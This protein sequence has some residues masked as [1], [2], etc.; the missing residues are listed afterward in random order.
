MTRV[1]SAAHTPQLLD[2]LGVGPDNAAALLITAGDN[3]SRLASDASFV[4]LCG[5][6]DGVSLL[7]VR[8]VRPG[9]IDYAELG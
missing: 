4:A 1:I 7:I 6:G 9:S 5:I 8:F 3:P 2:Q